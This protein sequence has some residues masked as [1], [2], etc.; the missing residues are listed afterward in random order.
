MA[1][2]AAGAGILLSTLSG[3]NGNKPDDEIAKTVGCSPRGVQRIKQNLHFYGKT[4]A[5]SNGVGR[6]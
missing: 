3:L 4:K 2:S 5:P 1:G 6:P